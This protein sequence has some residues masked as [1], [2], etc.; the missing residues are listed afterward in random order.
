MDAREAVVALAPP[1]VGPGPLLRTP[2]SKP[3]YSYPAGAAPNWPP[4]VVWT[5]A[6][7]HSGRAGAFR[8]TGGA[9]VRDR[10]RAV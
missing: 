6:H 5:T 3:R 10:R 9:G 2:S 1:G 4:L 7:A 8:G